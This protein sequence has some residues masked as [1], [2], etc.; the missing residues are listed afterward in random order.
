MRPEDLEAVAADASFLPE[1]ARRLGDP[2]FTRK[3]YEHSRETL[4]DF[5]R[6]PTPFLLEVFGWGAGR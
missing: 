1:L 3:L 5:F 4:L 2:L 6:R